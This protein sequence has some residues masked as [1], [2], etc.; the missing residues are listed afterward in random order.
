MK[1]FY[2]ALRSAVFLLLISTFVYGQGAIKGVVT[3]STNNDQLVGASVVIVGT[4]LGSATDL[5]GT[6]RIMKIP[7]GT[8]RLK[9]SYVGYLPRE[10]NITITDD[11]TLVFNIQLKPD[12]IEGEEIIITGQAIGQAAAINQQLTSNTI[13][14]VISEEK[15]QE[16]PD[17]NA[18][19]AIGRLPGVSLQRSGGEANKVVLRGL[20]DKFSS[21]TVDGIRIAATDADSRGVDLSTISQGSL[22]GIELFKALTPDKDA[23]AIAGSVNLVTKKAP[24][25]RLIRLDS[26]GVYNKL[27]DYLGQYDFSLRYGERF[28]DDILG[29][30]LTGNIERRDRSNESID[31]SWN[32]NITNGTDYEMTDFEVQYSDEIRKRKGISLLLDINTPDGGT[33]KINNIYNTT[34]RDYLVLARNYPMDGSDVTYSARDREQKINTFNSSIRGDNT[35]FGMSVNWGVSF[36]QSIGE[37]PYDY[38]VDFLEPSSSNSQMKDI[39]SEYKKGPAEAIISY[40][41]NNFE[42]A[43]MNVAYDRGE[44]NFDKEKAV[45]L[46]ISNKYAL[47]NYISGDVKIGGKY[48][49]KSRSKVASEVVAPYYLN[50]FKDYVKLDDGSVVSKDFS[51]TIFGN[52][53]TN[54]NSI[55][56]TNFL[57]SPVKDRDIY[58]KYNLTPLMNRDALRLWR[59]LNINGCGSTSGGDLEYSVNNE[60]DG[61][62]YDIVERVSSAYVMNTLNFGQN[63]TFIAGIRFES[64]NN[65]YKSRYSPYDLS[66]FPTPQGLIVDTSAAHKETVVLPNF[67]FTFR[68]FEFLNVRLAAYKALARPDFNRRLE[69]FIARKTGTFYSGNS[70]TIGNPNLKAAKAW[71]FEINTSIYGNEIGL[72]SISAFYK[73][74]KEMY[75]IV[76][77]AYV[78]GQTVLDNLGISWQQPFN[79]LYYYLTFPYNSDKPTRVWGFEVEHQTSL[80]FLPG[81]LQN[82]VLSYNFSIVRSETHIISTELEEYSTYITIGGKQVEVKK[83]RSVLVDLKEKLEGQPELF[84]NFAIGYDIGGFSGRLSIFYNGEYTRSFSANR[85]SDSVQDAFTRWDL[86]LKQVITDNI[87]VMFNLNNFTNTEEGTSIKNHITGWQLDNTSEKYGL[88]ADLGVRIEL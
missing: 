50:G 37:Y 19:E 13:I 12:I 28:F 48:R 76:N 47:G 71:N 2:F 85:R 60:T 18:A 21:I 24:S 87:S 55:L 69:N 1:S 25:E 57:D 56:L 30:Q 16:L 81:L 4:A 14:N 88:S 59:S 74:I 34:D 86:A 7:A 40:A 10:Y 54:G 32:Q 33:I 39:P 62:Y 73:D 78:K 84:G 45:F 15:I 43:F 72:F 3:D 64:E 70:L 83:S 23:D 31:Y 58:D 52:L 29:V 53:A 44:K 6:Y 38:T 66:G 27:N 41:W 77:G 67:H 26:K 22:A 51:G 35:L 5:E 49:S 75:H 42:A 11:K 46:D 9:T 68:P 8:Y 65:D 17:A 61:D 36:A 82:I 20:S 79:D 63:I 80:R